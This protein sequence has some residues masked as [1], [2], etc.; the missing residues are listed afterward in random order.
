MINVLI[1]L[2]RGMHRTLRKRAAQT[3]L[4]FVALLLYSMTGYMFFELPQ[5]PDLAWTDSFWWSVVTMTTV[6]Y[7]DFFPTTV[8]GRILIGFPTMLLGIGI[9]GYGLSQVASAMIESRIMENKGMKNLL[10]EKH[11]IV[12]NFSSIEKTLQIIHEIRSDSSTCDADIVIIDNQ[13]EELPAELVNDCTHFVKGD[14][15][16]EVTLEKANL[17]TCKAVIIQADNSDIHDSDNTN[18]R[19]CLTI[20]SICP[21]AYT[22]VECINPENEIFFKRAKCDSVISIASLTGQ[23]MIQELQDPGVNTIIAELTSNSKSKQIYITDLKAQANNY[24][25]V[26]DMYKADNVILLGIRRV[27]ENVILPEPG[28]AVHLGDKVILISDKRPS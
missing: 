7:G 5:N 10:L 24:R 12:C 21:E 15:S 1:I 8:P 25:D 16:R 17:K 26:Q 20:E 2:F 14:P 11:I 18:L 23:M 6:G 22:I 27:E 13:L 4:L 19:T 3:I 28:F 9:L